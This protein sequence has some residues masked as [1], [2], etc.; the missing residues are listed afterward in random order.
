MI[1][2]I[3]KPL[4]GNVAGN[5]LEY[6]GGGLNIDA[7]RVGGA[8]VSAGGNNFDAWR[9]G[10]DRLDRPSAHRNP[11]TK[12]VNGRWPPNLIRLNGIVQGFPDSNSNAQPRNRKPRADKTQYR[13]GGDHETVEYGDQG[14]AARFFYAVTGIKE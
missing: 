3:R 11:T 8:F 7:S 12:L 4:Q 1:T 5:V 6:R 9:S 10:Q 13:I 14:S 2:V